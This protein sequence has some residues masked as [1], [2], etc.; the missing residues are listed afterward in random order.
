MNMSSSH[1]LSQTFLFTL[2]KLSISRDEVQAAKIGLTANEMDRV[3]HMPMEEFT[4]SRRE[5]R[6]REFSPGYT[7]SDNKPAA[8]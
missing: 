4:V 5:G 6:L 7:G 2:A 1:Y 3:V 8:Q